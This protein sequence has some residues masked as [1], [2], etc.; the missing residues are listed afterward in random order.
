MF[1]YCVV[2]VETRDL[3][4]ILHSFVKR[5]VFTGRIRSMGKVMLSSV[6][7]GGGVDLCPGG[8][9][10]VSVQGWG[11]GH[12][13]QRPV[14][15]PLECI[16][17]CFFQP[18]AGGIGH[19]RSKGSGRVC[20]ETNTCENTTL[21]HISYVVGKNTHPRNTTMIARHFENCYRMCTTDIQECIEVGFVPP[22]G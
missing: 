19:K 14:R 21:P 13:R 4:R 9:R 3:I 1:K 5:A 11:G 20:M 10:G 16:L 12:L 15:I 17:V 7:G 2:S 8:G 18:W 6:H 22:A